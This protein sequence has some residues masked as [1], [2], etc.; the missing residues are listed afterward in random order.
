[1]KLRFQSLLRKFRTISSLAFNIV[2][3]FTSLLGI[4]ATSAGAAFLA[5]LHFQSWAIPILTFMLGLFVE[6]VL[7]IF[8]LLKPSP[9][10]CILTESKY[11][12]TACVGC[13]TST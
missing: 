11:V 5:W 3:F 9:P 12:T 2:Q 10:R 8:I 1:M 6:F 7:E 4:I 13:I